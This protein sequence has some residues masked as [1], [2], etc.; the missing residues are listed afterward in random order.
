MASACGRQIAA[1]RG[2]QQK[3][4]SDSGRRQSAGAA[5][6]TPTSGVHRQEPAS[7]NR[8]DSGDF[9]SR[10]DWAWGCDERQRQGEIDLVVISTQS[11]SEARFQVRNRRDSKRREGGGVTSIDPSARFARSG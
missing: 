7:R 11:T 5:G 2:P 1:D 3:P 4:E 6:A 9:V 10:R 8:S